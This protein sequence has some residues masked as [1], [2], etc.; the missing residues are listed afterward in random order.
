M[1]KIMKKIVAM[2]GALL[3]GAIA[4][5]GI[6]NFTAKADGDVEIRKPNLVVY[7]G[8]TLKD[9][10]MVAYV[11]PG[12]AQRVLEIAFQG[13]DASQ[14]EMV[15]CLLHENISSDFISLNSKQDYEVTAPEEGYT[16]YI[17]RILMTLPEQAGS[18]FYIVEPYKEGT[19]A[20]AYVEPAWLTA[21]KQVE[22]DTVKQIEGAQAG[23]TVVL[24]LG[25]FYNL[26]NAR[27]KMLA[28]KKDVT[29]VL[30]ITYRN[31]KYSLT[32]KPGTITD[33]GCDWYGPL[34]LLSMFPNETVK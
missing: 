33:L 2:T 26:S 24:E 16:G 34:K 9:A 14:E 6:P 3:L 31:V 12:M 21:W 32:V 1:K 11:K 30:H 13:D 7:E 27:M 8:D 5:A 19:A 22:Q 25:E 17:V 23:D 4:L 18:Y 10:S 15:A 29:F 28:E 20:A